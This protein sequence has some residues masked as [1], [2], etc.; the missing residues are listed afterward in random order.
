[1]M[2]IWDNFYINS[3]YVAITRA[4]KNIYIFEQL[5]EHPVLRL[6][7][8]QETKEGIK[9]SEVKSSKEEW[10]EERFARKVWFTNTKNANFVQVPTACSS[11]SF[12]CCATSPVRSG[13]HRRRKMKR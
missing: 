13:L 9:V 8:M 3:F 4:I 1:M 12:S 6:L 5:V 2:N 7:Q 11:F 10:L